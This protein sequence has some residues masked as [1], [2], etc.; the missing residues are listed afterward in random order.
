MNII[1]ST[2]SPLLYNRLETILSEFHDL[3]IMKVTKDLNE[4]EIILRNCPAKVLITLFHKID[5][6]VLNKLKQIKCNNR[7]LVV[8]VLNNNPADQYLTQWKNAGANY[9]FDQAMHYNKLID[10]LAGLIYKDLLT[11]LKSAK[12]IKN[13]RNLNHEE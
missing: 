8:I 11:T 3:R 2:D 13:R 7:K 6:S 12:P 4:T 1:V 10:V 9:V 5:K